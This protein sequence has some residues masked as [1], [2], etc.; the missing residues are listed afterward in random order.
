MANKKKVKVEP[1]IFAVISTDYT[2]GK[3]L[4]VLNSTNF[5]Y[6]VESLPLY[7]ERGS[8]M[9]MQVWHKGS[10]QQIYEYR[11]GA[12]ELVVDYEEEEE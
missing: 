10:I 4:L 8:N 12:L 5:K 1:K 3:E 11:D 2:S 9:F 6:I 7:Y